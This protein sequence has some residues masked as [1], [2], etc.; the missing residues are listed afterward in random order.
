[1]VLSQSLEHRA[2]VAV[3]CAICLML[4]PPVLVRHSG[5]GKTLGQAPKVYGSMARVGFIGVFSIANVK[6]QCLHCL[7]V[8]V[9]IDVFI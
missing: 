4:I 2:G 8:V 5:W 3:E 9:L 6:E 7:H 1:M